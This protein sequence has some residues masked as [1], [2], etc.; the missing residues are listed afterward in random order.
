[1]RLLSNDEGGDK[2]LRKR[3]RFRKILMYTALIIGLASPNFLV[4]SSSDRIWKIG[5]V[6]IAIWV[7][8]ALL[9][10]FLGRREDSE[11]QGKSK[12]QGG[13]HVRRDEK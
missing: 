12:A 13:A 1:M 5:V 6:L 3:R 4:L 2:E 9:E 7:P 11:E 8:V 10:N